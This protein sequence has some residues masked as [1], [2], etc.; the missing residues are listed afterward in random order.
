MRV[1]HHPKAREVD[2]RTGIGQ[3]IINLEPRMKKLGVEYVD[4]P[5][6]AEII[7]T[8]VMKG[9]LPT[10]D[11]LHCHGLYFDDQPHIPYD[12]WHY[13]INR[14]IAQTARE[15][16]EII[17]PS[18]WVAEPFKR[19]MRRSPVVI[20]HG[21]DAHLWKREKS[22]G[23][24]L[25]NKNR[26]SD[27]CDPM[28]ATLL[29]GAGF[30]VMSTFAQKDLKTLPE[31]LTVTGALSF[32]D[33][34]KVIQKAGIYLATTIETFGIGTLEA[35]AS[36]VPVLGFSSGSTPDIV[37]HMEHGYLV[38][39]GDLNG[40][41]AGAQYINDNWDRLS[42]NCIKKAQ[43]Y[44]WDEVAKIYLA[45]YERALEKKQQETHKVSI[46]IPN[47]NYGRFIQEAVDTCL[48]QDYPPDE[49]IIVDD[50]ST[51]DSL[52]VLKKYSENPKVSVIAQ[53]NGGVAS[54]RNNG[55]EK[56][57]NPY[58]VCLDADDRLH[59][60]FLKV[61][62]DAM[63][64]DRS[65]GVAYTGLSITHDTG[66]EVPSLG[67]PPEFNWEGQTSVH[68]PPSNCVPSACMFRK[69]M[70]ERCG[71][72]RQVYAPGEDAEFWTR[73]LSIG[74]NA[75]R[76]T[77]EG[78]FR[79]RIH[80]N[81]ASRTKKYTAIDSWMPWMRDR[82][83]P[84]ASPMSVTTN[85]HVRS[86]ISPNVSVIMPLC[87]E[88]LRIVES[89][90]ESIIGQT[91]RQWELIIVGDKIQEQDV[92]HLKKKYPF[93]KFFFTNKGAG[94]ARNVGIK[95]AKSP[96]V[97]FLDADD[98]VAPSTLERLVNFH[99]IN[100]GR[101]V[102]TDWFSVENGKEPI[103]HETEHYDQNAWFSPSPYGKDYLYGIHA[104]S[105]LML[106]SQ[107]KEILFDE[108]LTGW[109]DWDFFVK[110][111]IKGYCGM[112]YPEPL[113]YYRLNTGVRRKETMSGKSDLATKL[114][115]RYNN[116][117]RSVTMGS[118]CG[119]NIVSLAKDG[120]G[121]RGDGEVVRMEYT[122][123]NQGAISF[124]VQ[125]R[126]YRGGA[127]ALNRYIDALKEHV[128]YLESTGKWRIVVPV[129]E[130]VPQEM[131]KMDE[132]KEFTALD[133][134]EKEHE[135]Q[136]VSELGVKETLSDEDEAIEK[137]IAQSQKERKVRRRL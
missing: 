55:I 10:V 32:E 83:F 107:A 82:D 81:S 19:D 118:C 28:Y 38:K 6:Q 37:T 24:I 7:A 105:V 67:W 57:S 87:K 123:E 46:V 12:S 42:K 59:K 122:G 56:A 61:L 54:A 96:Y 93:I 30:D 43:E 73:G 3:V 9:S 52:E 48:D 44:S 65:L 91:T 94:A 119:G 36:G 18:E 85:V 132:V 45:T 120:V 100:P 102:Y 62:R 136:A 34:K 75:K 53:K 124:N 121:T 80:G 1:F 22:E 86:Y 64:K 88:H 109:E 58:I 17:A 90:I 23:Y 110:C 134:P 135:P 35:M 115:S 95:K 21:I 47:Y 98:Y 117:E 92:S 116:S 31:K 78:L 84:F 89:A 126:V 104:V 129:V 2:E 76:V 130:S 113:L 14:E 127:N 131:V 4:T 97:F 16:L 20:P 137:E 25:W 99:K 106:T 69:D 26:A 33:M 8:H 27:V 111:A 70:W 79:Y 51:D 112:R 71:G 133:E 29:A 49:I 39:H 50:G 103:K 114:M 68:V 63:K 72:F 125:G 77:T 15:S 108:T 60:P 41:I 128:A 40:L 13:R 74:F 11:V 66:E 101:Y 5:E